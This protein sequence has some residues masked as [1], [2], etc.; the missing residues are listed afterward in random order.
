M[1][2]SRAA[3]AANADCRLSL[4]E[5]RSATAAPL[6]QPLSLLYHLDAA[7]NHQEAAQQAAVRSRAAAPAALAA[8][9]KLANSSRVQPAPA[10]QQRGGARPNATHARN[11][12]ASVGTVLWHWIR[13][14]GRAYKPTLC[15]QEG[16]ILSSPV[17]RI[18]DYCMG[19]RGPQPARMGGGCL[20]QETSLYYPGC[21]REFE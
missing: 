12:I 15:S 3:A 8:A 20:F 18:H 6:R 11:V 17:L 10:S 5:F 13:P 7:G 2:A 4:Q 14:N 16:T 19:F 21:F 9:A 1:S